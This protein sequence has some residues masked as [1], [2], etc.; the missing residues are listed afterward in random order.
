MSRSL[1]WAWIF[2]LCVGLF[3]LLELLGEEHDG[4]AT[5]ALSLMVPMVGYELW[6]AV[7]RIVK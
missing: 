3:A 5:T 6:R 4:A 7:E 2:T 1:E